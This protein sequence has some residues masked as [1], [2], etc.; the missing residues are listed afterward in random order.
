MF[1]ALN[2]R[3]RTRNIAKTAEVS[4]RKI[5]LKEGRK[6]DV[7]V[8]PFGMIRTKYHDRFGGQNHKVF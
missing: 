6:A 2:H 4:S 3:G 1:F 8:S 5:R 7:E